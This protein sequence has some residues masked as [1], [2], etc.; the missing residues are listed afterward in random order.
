MDADVKHFCLCSVVYFRN[1]PSPE[2]TTPVTLLFPVLNNL[3][4]GGVVSNCGKDPVNWLVPIPN[5][6]TLARFFGQVRYSDGTGPWT[7]SLLTAA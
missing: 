5:F 4:P 1:F 6:W 3:E 2:G 7:W